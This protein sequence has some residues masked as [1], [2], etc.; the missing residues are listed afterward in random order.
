MT[1][2]IPR[3]EFLCVRA[4]QQ[5][6]QS[7]TTDVLSL[8]LLVSIYL[9]AIHYRPPTKLRD[10]NV[11]SRVCRQSVFLSTYVGK[12]VVDIRLKCLLVVAAFFHLF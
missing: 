5:G 7:I 11:F 3:R 9:N 10:G 2:E 4:R 8:V 1:W 6:I 12:R